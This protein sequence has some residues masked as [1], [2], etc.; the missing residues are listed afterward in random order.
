MTEKILEHIFGPSSHLKILLFLHKLDEG[1]KVNMKMIKQKTGS[2][3]PTM[4]RILEH[5]RK[6]NIIIVTGATKSR[7]IMVNPKSHSRKVVWKFLDD[8][9]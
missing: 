7:L 4:V 3:Y 9:K 5:L 2:A 1:Q 6:A 8:F